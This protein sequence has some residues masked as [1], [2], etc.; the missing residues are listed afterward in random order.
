V[1]S[2]LYCAA[3]VV[4]RENDN[5]AYVPELWAREGLEVLQENMVMAGLVHR[6]FENTIQNFGDTVN[7]RRPGEFQTRRKGQSDQIEIQDAVST[8]VQVRLDQH[9]YES[10]II[11]DQEASLS[12]A[13]LA[14][15]YLVE[16]MRA[17]GRTV[18]RS[19]TAKAHQLTN[20][21]GRLG[22]LSNAN[23]RDMVL[24]VREKLNI[25]KATPE[26]RRLV[27]APQSET[28]LLGTDLFLKANERGDGGT[29]LENALLGRILGFDT[30]M[31]Q[32]VPGLTATNVDTASG[33]VTNALAAG[34]SGSQTVAITGHEVTVGEYFTVAGDDQPNYATAKTSGTG[35]T[36]AVTGANANVY[37][38]AAG[39]VIKVYKSCAVN[40]AYAAGYTKGITLD[41][42]TSGK[43]PQVGQIV[44]FGTGGSRKVY[45]VIDAWTDG[46][47]R[48]VYLDRPLEV[49]LADNDAAFPGPAG[50]FNLA[51][52]RDAISLVSRP[53]ATPPSAAGVM[54]AVATGYDLAMRV[55]L[56]YDIRSQGTVVTCDLLYGTA[57]LDNALAAI[58]LG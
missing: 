45:T 30:F 43:P 34:G 27:L 18:D 13:E 9:A 53:L 51:F 35:D 21:V 1:L 16:A 31:S 58:L 52:H 25:N 46:S 26:G 55:T 41:G 37:A 19:L 14:P 57:I 50:A 42:F 7:T 38:T 33:T 20:L 10:F 44:A 5:D 29:A 56:Q 40:G 36:T 32:N 17:V 22:N 6:D 23:A 3:F 12:F 48:I 49:A 28:S 39:A 2:L 11:K 54:G 15:I 24:S 47:T 8:N 4:L